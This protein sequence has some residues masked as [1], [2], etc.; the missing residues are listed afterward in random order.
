MCVQYSVPHS[1]FVFSGSSSPPPPPKWSTPVQRGSPVAA[2]SAVLVL[3]L[4]GPNG[5]VFVFGGGDAVVGRSGTGFTNIS[6]IFLSF[7][8]LFSKLLLNCF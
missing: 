1:I 3:L 2:T 8:Y 7:F 6:T 4:S 5:L